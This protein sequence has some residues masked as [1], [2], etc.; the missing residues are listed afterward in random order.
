VSLICHVVAPA[1]QRDFRRSEAALDADVSRDNYVDFTKVETVLAEGYESKGTGS[2][3][4]RES[5]LLLPARG[6]ES[7]AST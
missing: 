2:T 3:A 6:R 7:G 5:K 1:S 4:Q